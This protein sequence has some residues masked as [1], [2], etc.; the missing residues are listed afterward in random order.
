MNT[1]DDAVIMLK[2]RAEAFRNAGLTSD[3][4]KEAA[5]LAQL[6]GSLDPA[7]LIEDWL[8][9]GHKGQITLGVQIFRL[10]N[11]EERHGNNG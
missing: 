6:I 10:K 4:E 8:P 1:L 9:I 11:K 7:W 3:A 5:K 2:K